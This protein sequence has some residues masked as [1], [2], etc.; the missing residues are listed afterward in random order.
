MS[1]NES[2]TEKHLLDVSL[3]FQ[4]PYLSL[5]CCHALTHSTAG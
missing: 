2:F 1:H 4:Q 5:Q 3:S